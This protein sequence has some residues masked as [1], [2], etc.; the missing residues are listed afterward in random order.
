MTRKP[1]D[2]PT[3]PA[4]PSELLARARRRGAQIKLHRRV[5]AGAASA[6]VAAGLAVPLSLAAGGSTR[7]VVQ[8]A[9]PSTTNQA[10]SRTTSPPQSI[11]ATSPT[12]P[13]PTGTTVRTVVRQTPVSTTNSGTPT[14]RTTPAPVSTTVP[15]GPTT[16]TVG[17][18]NN[19]Q[20][21]SIAVG[22]TLIVQL[23]AD[24]W[25]IPPSSQPAVLAMEGTPV[26]QRQP[27]VPG[28]TCGTTTATFHAQQAGQAEVFASRTYCGE[29]IMCQP[30]T[31]SWSI[32]V[33]VTG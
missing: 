13:A 8:V 17:D 11:G 19:G 5:A 24:N 25:T 9:G 21:I 14:T 26:Q 15:A 30:S 16:R 10:A 28:G 3:G 22:S 1:S 27:C 7:H 29:A 32:T 20:T 18:S 23:N 4:S 12:A 31:D 6:A 33:Q 2:Q